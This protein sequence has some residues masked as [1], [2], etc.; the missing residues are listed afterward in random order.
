MNTKKSIRCLVFLGFILVLVVGML[1]A[2]RLITG[3]SFGLVGLMTSLPHSAISIVRASLDRGSIQNNNHGNFTNIVFLHHS[4]GEGMIAQGSL[5]QQFTEA[6]YAFYDHDY[7]DIG[8]TNV[9]GQPAGYS[10]RVPG[11]NTD[12]D[13]L[14]TIFQQPVYPLPSNTLSGLFQHEVILVKSCFTN[15]HISS[16]DQLAQDQSEYLEIRKV[17][18]DHPEKLFIILTS[19]PLNPA[20]TNFAEAGQAKKLADWLVSDQFKG[21]AANITVFDLFNALAEKDPASP[22]AN[23][24]REDYRNGNDS[25]PNQVANEIVGRMLVKFIDDAAIKYRTIY[26]AD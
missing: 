23:Q 20:E 9:D 6:G 16:D 11:D 18:Q 5:R 4:V 13:G 17:M 26:P 24:L 8:L 15:N 7:N 12:I 2:F 1:G 10:Y 19:P 22:E 21:D 14:V 3:R 25:H